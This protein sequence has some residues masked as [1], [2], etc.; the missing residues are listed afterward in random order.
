MRRC[1]TSGATYS[2]V[3]PNYTTSVLCLVNLPHY[4]NLK[5][6]EMKRLKKLLHD[7]LEEVLSDTF[8]F[9][10]YTRFGGPRSP[11]YM[12]VKSEGET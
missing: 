10:S 11:R 12:V 5:P 9:N 1:K 3:V 8:D 2:I 7:S 6:S 4:L